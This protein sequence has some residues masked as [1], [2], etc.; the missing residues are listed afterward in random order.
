MVLLGALAQ[1]SKTVMIA[2]PYFL[3]DSSLISALNT[4]ALRGIAVDILLPEKNNLRLV[5][6]AS[7]AHY[8][9][10]LERGCRIWHSPPPFD[11]SKVVLVDDAWTLVGSTN[12]DPRSLRLNF[13]LN[14]ECYDRELNARMRSWFQRR[15]E[16]STAVTTAD[17]E[18]S[19]LP[20]RLRDG[21]A[22][23]FSPYL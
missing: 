17:I 11:H 12:W 22:R 2:T 16:V 8:W 3:P 6:W 9:Q 10:L 20:Q 19:S 1:A 15:L 4:A 14:F 18:G 23:L 5:Q 13:E 21:A 7:F